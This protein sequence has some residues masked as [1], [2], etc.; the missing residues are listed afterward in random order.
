[1]A[2]DKRGRPIPVF[3]PPPGP[4]PMLA[5][6]AQPSPHQVDLENEVALLRADLENLRT[7]VEVL[8]NMTRAQ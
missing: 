1:M 2:L 8:Q 4:P 3:V 5:A 6:L 7:Q